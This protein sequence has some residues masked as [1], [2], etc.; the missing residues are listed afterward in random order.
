MVGIEEFDLEGSVK[1]YPNPANNILNIEL[2]EVY[3]VVNMRIL[4]ILGKEVQQKQFN[5]E[6]LLKIDISELPTGP[7]FIHLKT[8][9]GKASIRVVKN[10]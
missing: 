9:E 2:D 1:V 10:K 6:Q 4:N 5:R 3:E 7:Y 8:P